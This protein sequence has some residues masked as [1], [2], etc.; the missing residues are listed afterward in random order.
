MLETLRLAHFEYGQS[1]NIYIKDL[2]L[3][4]ITFLFLLG[5]Y[6]EPKKPRHVDLNGSM[7][8]QVNHNKSILSTS[9]VEAKSQIDFHRADDN[10]TQPPFSNLTYKHSKPTDVRSPIRPGGYFV[11]SSTQKATPFQNHRFQQRSCNNP[12]RESIPEERSPSN[13]HFTKSC[14]S[15]TSTDVLS[16]KKPSYFNL[17]NEP[18][19][20]TSSLFSKDIFQRKNAKLQAIS[21]SNYCIRTSL[22]RGEEPSPFLKKYET[23]NEF[24]MTKNK[25]M[26]VSKLLTEDFEVRDQL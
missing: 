5:V 23:E 25:D 20:Q 2:T 11:S 1:M 6:I 9:P 16:K 24:D 22:F 13:N 21:A 7:H 17:Y 15:E 10:H 14:N 3:L 8:S 12:I 4:T 26:S 18:V 19:E